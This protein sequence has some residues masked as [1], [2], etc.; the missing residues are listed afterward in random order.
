MQGN[1]LRLKQDL[2]EKGQK[3]VEMKKKL[4]TSL[5][6]WK[7]L[8]QDLVHACQKQEII[9]EDKRKGRKNK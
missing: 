3:K 7:R 8:N 1:C 2:A 6:F 5:H 9:S 4:W